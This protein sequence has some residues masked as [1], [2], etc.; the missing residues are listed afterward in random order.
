[1]KHARLVSNALYYTEVYCTI[2]CNICCN[3]NFYLVTTI[4]VLL[5]GAEAVDKAT[6]STQHLPDQGATASREV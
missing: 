3:E 2:H 4:I 1:M 6:S 5:A